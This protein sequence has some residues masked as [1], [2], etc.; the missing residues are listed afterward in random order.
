M[1]P[2]RGPSTVCASSSPIEGVIVAGPRHGGV[3]L[4]AV[5]AW[6]SGVLA[7]IGGI[8]IW[9]GTSI[10]FPGVIWAAWISII[11]GVITI[12]VGFGLLL[13]SNVARII[14]TIVFL[15]NLGSAILTM[16]AAPD[17]LWS[18]IGSGL[19]ALIGLILLYTEKANLF[20][21]PA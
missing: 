10:D 20:F 17:Q 8:I 9:L 4:I 3:T 21:R 12:A 16:F 5:L 2:H 1:P 6:I 18:S 15:L 13:G 11:I 14:A 7:L 19:L